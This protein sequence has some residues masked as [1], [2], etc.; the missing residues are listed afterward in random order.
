LGHSPSSVAGGKG[1][2]VRPCD[3]KPQWV[4]VPV[5]YLLAR[6]GLIPAIR[7]DDPA[8]M[9][10]AKYDREG[11]IWRVRLTAAD[12]PLHVPIYYSGHTLLCPKTHKRF[13]VPQ[14]PA[15]ATF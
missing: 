14:I 15:E 9:L 10:P 7:Q 5:L 8:A 4:E 1:L 3:V 13:R 2:A 12:E 6:L 11:Q